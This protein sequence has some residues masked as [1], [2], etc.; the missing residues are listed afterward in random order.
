MDE[1][2]P[3]FDTGNLIEAADKDDY[4][5]RYLAEKYIDRATLAPTKEGLKLLNT[6]MKLLTPAE[7]LL[8]KHLVRFLR[9][10]HSQ[11]DTTAFSRICGITAK[12]AT[13]LYALAD[14]RDLALVKGKL[15]LTEKEAIAAAS[16]YS[17]PETIKALHQ[18]G[19]MSLE[20]LRLLMEKGGLTPREHLEIMRSCFATAVSIKTALTDKKVGVDNDDPSTWSDEELISKAEHLNALLDRVRRNRASGE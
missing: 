11:P 8:L 2:D 4:T 14:M 13:T 3:I 1:A 10:Q 18:I 7:R 15:S 6:D 19:S 5:R 16:N 12:R 20:H 17:T 9:G